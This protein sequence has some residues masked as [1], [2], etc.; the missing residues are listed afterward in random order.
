[1]PTAAIAANQVG[2]YEIALTPSTE[3]TVDI[4]LG[5]AVTN[6]IEVFDHTASSPDYVKSGTT[7]VTVKDPAARMLVQGGSLV[8]D[9]DYPAG[10][11][12]VRLVSS[13]AAVVSVART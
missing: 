7:A 3:A 4:T 8:V 10:V 6:D 9:V 13:A 1:M 5:T 2:A 12:T 11:G